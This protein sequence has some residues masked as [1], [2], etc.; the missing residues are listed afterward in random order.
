MSDGDG[1]L[2]KYARLVLV[3]VFE[4]VEVGANEGLNIFTMMAYL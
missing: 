2:P 4:G 1:V 3:L